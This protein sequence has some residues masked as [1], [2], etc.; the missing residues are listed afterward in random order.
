[1][2]ILGTMSLSAITLVISS[3]GNYNIAEE[4]TPCFVAQI[5]CQWHQ[6]VSAFAVPAGIAL[7]AALFIHQRR[8]PAFR[9]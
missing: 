3:I 6:N 4:G 8:L 2:A 9:A 7:A 5:Y 1:M